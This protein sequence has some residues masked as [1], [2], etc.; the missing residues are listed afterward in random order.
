MQ[1]TAMVFCAMGQK[2]HLEAH[3]VHMWFPDLVSAVQICWRPLGQQSGDRTAI[4]KQ[5]ACH[6]TVFAY[7]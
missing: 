3:K 5:E 7:A 6:A 2:Q 1:D 4:C